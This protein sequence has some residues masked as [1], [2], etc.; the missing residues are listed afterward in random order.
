METLFQVAQ[1]WL[2]QDPDLETRAELEQLISQAKA[3]DAKAQAE[4][5]SR[6]DGRLQ[7]GT[8]GLR[9]RLQAGSMGMN[10]VLVA[11]AA[12]GLAEFLKGYD[13]EPSIVLGY[14]GRKNSDVFARDTAEIMAAAGIKTYLLPRK[15]PTPVLAYAIKYFD[16]TA[17][18]MVTASHNPPEDNGYKVYLGKANGG[19]QIVSPADQE[20][21]ACIDKVAQGSIKDLPRSQNYTVLDDE[22]VDAYIAKTASLAKE[23]QVDINYVY[24]AMHGVGYEVL[25][26]TLAK[27][28][29]PQP[30]IVAEQV[31]PDGTFPTVNFPNPE[32]KGAL[33][34]AIK[35]AKERNAEFIIANDPDA[36]RLAVAVPDA[37]GNWKPLHGNVIG[38]FLGWYLAKQYHAQG[39]KGVLACSLVSSP[40]LA[41]IANKYGFESEETLTGFKYIGKVNGLL[42]GFEEALGYLVDPD[43]VRDKDGI[44]AA[45]M[46]LDLVRNLKKQGKTLADYADDF[47]REFGA[48]VSGQISIRVD[49]LSAIGKLMTALRTNPPS[50]VGGFKVATFLDHTKTDRQSDI[51][52]FVLENGS[53]LIA[54]PS[55]TEPKI[56][57]YLDARGTDPKNA[58]EVLAQFDASVRAIL[59]QEQYGKQ[60]C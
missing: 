2:D 35:V 42:F 18:V 34:L 58:E 22:I 21:A 1:N 55:G 54:R 15:L 26:K 8:A 59:R 38:C 47:T 9:G 31:W 56:K 29:L 12:G 28:G 7:F 19:G 25:S 32:E 30:S 23:P 45:I 14:D 36:D 52:V 53:R 60:G 57:F 49:D 46:F 24:T 13:K 37:Q 39:K 51:L 50:E 48:Y 6:F 20:I 33:D 44:S 16:T 27:A 10:R 5:S 43:K 17:G 40:A 11:Q 4:L 41:E 3:N